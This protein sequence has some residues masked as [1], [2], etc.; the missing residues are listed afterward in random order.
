M[1]E[2]EALHAPL[3][4]ARRAFDKLNTEIATDTADVRS[5][6]A[7]R[8][9]A[10]ENLNELEMAAALSGKPMPD[11][12]ELDQR[13]AQL[14]RGLYAKKR[15]ASI[16]AGRVMREQMMASRKLCELKRP[17]FDQ[18]VRELANNL[19]AVNKSAERYYALTDSINA[20]GSAA[21]LPLPN[22]SAI[23]NGRDRY[24]PL[25]FFLRDARDAGITK[26]SEIPEPLR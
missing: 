14:Q 11:T 21:S 23:S 16:L 7:N 22:M 1:D 17:Q 6:L 24:S 20:V 12:N 19:L 25:G 2:L 3:A 15:A 8:Q 26:T 13:L 9:R 18:I 5:L 10:I 4:E